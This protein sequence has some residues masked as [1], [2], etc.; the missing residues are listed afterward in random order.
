VSTAFPTYLWH[1]LL[2]RIIYDH[3]GVALAAGVAVALLV[4]RR[5]R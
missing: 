4:A 2:A 3:A 1:Y 5:R